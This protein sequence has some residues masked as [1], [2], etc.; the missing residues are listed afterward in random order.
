MLFY[1]PFK[2]S[3]VKV[4]NVLIINSQSDEKDYPIVRMHFDSNP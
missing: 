2:K 4:F 3:C 1:K